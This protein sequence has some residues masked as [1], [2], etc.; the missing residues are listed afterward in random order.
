MTEARTFTRKV[1]FDDGLPLGERATFTHE[2]QRWIAHPAQKYWMIANVLD[3]L[4]GLHDSTAKLMVAWVND[5][6]GDAKRVAQVMEIG[7]RARL[8]GKSV[9]MEKVEALTWRRP[10]DAASTSPDHALGQGSGL[11]GTNSLTSPGLVK[12]S[13]NECPETGRNRHLREELE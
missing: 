2:G 10:G 5:W 9:T 6:P 12:E 1:T 4:I 13:I 3:R 11:P 7:K 8:L